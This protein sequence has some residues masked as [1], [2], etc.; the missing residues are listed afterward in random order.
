MD[1]IISQKDLERAINGRRKLKIVS[2]KDDICKVHPPVCEKNLGILRES[3]PQFTNK[4]IK[5]MLKALPD[6]RF[7]EIE[8]DIK[9]RGEGPAKRDL[10]HTERELFHDRKNAEAAVAEGASPRSSKSTFDEF[11]DRLKKK[12]EI[13]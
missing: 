8:E 5:E 4:P 1:G 6:S 9:Q 3:M 7:Q 12:G 11:V 2:D 13:G 10:S